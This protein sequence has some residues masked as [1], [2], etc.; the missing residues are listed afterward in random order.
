M[1]DGCG[2]LYIGAAHDVT[3]RITMPGWWNNPSHGTVLIDPDGFVF[4]S[5]KRRSN[6]MRVT[7]MFSPVNALSGI[8]V[9]AYD[10]EPEW[11]NGCSGRQPL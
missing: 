8:T 9:T 3:D 10:Y 1:R 2:L 6:M 4:D 7:G 11:D 5:A